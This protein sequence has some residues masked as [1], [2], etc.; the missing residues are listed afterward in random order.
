MAENTGRLSVQASAAIASG[1]SQSAAIDMRE[2]VIAALLMP[3]AWDL[4]AITFLACDTQGGT[5]LPV[6]DDA[7]TEVTIASANAVAG[8]AIVNKTVLEQ[9]A[10]I[11]WLKIRSGV[12]ATPVNQTADRAI[13]VSLKS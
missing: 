8:R 6:Y 11:R 3:A 2:Y 9:L 1:T 10:G 7:G 4:A 12:A 13:I 5:F